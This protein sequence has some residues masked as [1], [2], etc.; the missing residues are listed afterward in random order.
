MNEEM[1]VRQ[2][3][4]E[5][6]GSI[7]QPADEQSVRIKIL[8]FRQGL[9]DDLNAFKKNPSARNFTSL[10]MTMYWYQYWSQKATYEEV[11]E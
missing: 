4:E 1:L 10:K 5:K 6:Y 11:E 2:L 9:E 7:H 8:A 3:Q